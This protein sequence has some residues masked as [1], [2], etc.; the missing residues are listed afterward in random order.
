[1]QSAYFL[2]LAIQLNSC[3]RNLN[4]YPLDLV[5][6]A[7]F[8]KPC[9]DDIVGMLEAITSSSMSQS[10]QPPVTAATTQAVQATGKGKPASAPTSTSS[11]LTGRD[12]LFALSSLLR[13]IDP[14]WEFGYEFDYIADLHSSLIANF[15]IYGDKCSIKSVPRLENIEL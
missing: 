2:K 6:D 13:E 12:A 7:S 5:A 10:R 9:P 14:L 15:P 8:S 4:D 1:M 3:I 11:K